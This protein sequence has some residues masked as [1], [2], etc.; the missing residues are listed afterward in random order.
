MRYLIVLAALIAA[1][2]VPTAGAQTLPPLAPHLQDI[3]DC[4]DPDFPP[5]SPSGQCATLIEFV[6]D[7]SGNDSRWRCDRPLPQYGP[8]PIIVNHVQPNSGSNPPGAIGLGDTPGQYP[9]TGCT[10]PAQR[11]GGTLPTCNFDQKADLFLQI[12][13]N[14][15]TVGSNNDL[16][17]TYGAHCIEIGDPQHS[18]G[19]WY[20][21]QV[22]NGAHQDGHNCNYCRG[23]HYYGIEIGDWETLTSGAHGAGGLWYMDWLDQDGGADNSHHHDDIVCFGCKIVGSNHPGGGPIGTGLSFGESDN[24]GMVN[25]CIAANHPLTFFASSTRGSNQINQGNF[26]IDR[27]DGTPDNPQG[28]P[29]FDGNEPPPPPP[30]DPECDDG[31]DNDG[32]GLVDLADPGCENAADDDEFDSPPPP[33]PDGDG[34][35]VPDEDDNCPAAPNPGQEDTDGDG[36]GDA[37]DEPTW[38][39]FRM[40]QERA[41]AAEEWARLLEADLAACLDKLSRVDA[42]AHRDWTDAHKL[43]RMEGALHRASCPF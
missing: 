8:L 23:L 41:E 16:V 19:T 28:C 22:S 26:F 33:D 2:F 27:D 10:V 11:V 30:P 31:L 14:R 29:L 42:F 43:R 35:G 37:C 4:D 25:S 20:G 34:D 9:A 15:T 7:G 5:Q 40:L 3:V 12:N 24:S 38:A 13:G 1:F 18:G 32:D 39:E 17:K 6:G 21:G 36:S